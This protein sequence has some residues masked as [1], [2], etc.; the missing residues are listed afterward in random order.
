MVVEQ[1]RWIDEESFIEGATIARALPGTNV[2]NL[3]SFVGAVLRG[4][5]G[6]ACATSGVLAPGVVA[7]CAAAAAYAKLDAMHGAIGQGLLRGLTAGALGVMAV[8]VKDAARVGMK[9]AR[10]VAFAMAAFA[11][12]GIF[13]VNMAAVLAI[14]V[15]LAA[16][17]CG[18][19]PTRKV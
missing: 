14:L 1:R 10:T 6:A 15:P 17:V 7:V 3:A 19:G 2:T 5:W 13:Y 4:P 11:A 16:L 9:G 8:L 12:V 18:A